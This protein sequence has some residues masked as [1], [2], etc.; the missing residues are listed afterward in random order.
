[1]VGSNCISYIMQERDVAYVPVKEETVKEEIVDTWYPSEAPRQH[2]SDA[3]SPPC[4][5]QK[6]T[7]DPYM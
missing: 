3:A 7:D 2:N 1:M 6:A 5:K 4:K